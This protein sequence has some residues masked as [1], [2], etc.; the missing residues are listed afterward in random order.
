M[1]QLAEQKYFSGRDVVK[2]HGYID[3][4]DAQDIK[5]KDRN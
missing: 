1:K 5:V 3:A 2:H 4:I